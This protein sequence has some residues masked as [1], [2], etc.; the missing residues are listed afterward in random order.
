MDNVRRITLTKCLARAHR[1]EPFAADAIACWLASPRVGARSSRTLYVKTIYLV[2]MGHGHVE[3]DDRGIGFPAE[4]CFAWDPALFDRLQAE[5][6][7]GK[8]DL[9]RQHPLWAEAQPLRIQIEE[10]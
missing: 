1:G 4:D 7:A 3:Q 2:R 8:E 6:G 5:W 10:S 9:S